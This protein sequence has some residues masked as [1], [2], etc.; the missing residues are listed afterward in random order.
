[1]CFTDPEIVK[2]GMSP[3]EATAAGI[4]HL[5]GRFMLG[6]N[7]RALSLDRDDGFVRIVARRDNHLVLGLQAVGAGVS[8]LAAAFTTTLEMGSVL[9][10]I[11]ATVHAHPSI[12]EAVQEA[13][14]AALGRAIHRA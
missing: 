13:A 2:V 4:D 10:D 6:A 7:G 14:L 12:S 1:V 11:A 8:E 9:D 5:V 3:D